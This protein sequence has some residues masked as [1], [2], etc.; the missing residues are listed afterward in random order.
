[1]RDSRAKLVDDV[2]GL[3]DRFGI[4][5]WEEKLSQRGNSEVTNNN[6]IN[7]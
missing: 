1:M 4:V 5:A 7:L 3:L 6:K 2:D